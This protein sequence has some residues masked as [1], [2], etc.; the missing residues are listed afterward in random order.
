[1]SPADA[2]THISN[3]R[4]IMTKRLAVLVA[5]LATILALGQ[6]PAR[7]AVDI[8]AGI[9]INATAD[10]N[11]PLQPYGTWVD[12]RS[13]GR[14]WHPTQIEADWRPYTVGHWEWTDAGWYWVSDEPWAWACYHYG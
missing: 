5:S 8:S 7:A 1:M 14:C 9:Q 2:S 4:R 10:F 3:E 6:Y 11:A 12:F 13:Y